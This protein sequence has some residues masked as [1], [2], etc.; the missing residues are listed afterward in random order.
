MRSA[1]HSPLAACLLG[2]APAPFLEMAVSLRR[3]VQGSS[4]RGRLV[5]TLPH[6]RYLHYKCS[7]CDLQPFRAG[8]DGV[9]RHVMHHAG[10][11]SNQVRKVYFCEICQ[12]Y[13][14]VA[15]TCVHD[16]ERLPVPFTTVASLAF[17]SELPP[18]VMALLYPRDFAILASRNFPDGTAPGFIA[19]RAAAGTASW[20]GR[21]WTVGGTGSHG[22]GGGASTPS[23]NLLPSGQASGSGLVAMHAEVE[24]A[25]ARAGMTAADIRRA[26]AAMVDLRG[27]NSVYSILRT[28]FKATPARGAGAGAPGG[29]Y[30][31]RIT[32]LNNEE[33]PAYILQREFQYHGA[34]L[35]DEL[36]GKTRVAH[37][38]L[39]QQLE[40]YFVPHAA[41][42]PFYRNFDNHGRGLHMGVREGL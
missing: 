21:A 27:V 22:G 13:S 23:S 16:E 40:D 10:A 42:R 20:A 41:S 28:F 17:R 3:V 38:F 1:Q 6:P 8:E 35:V 4:T 7:D 24:I 31:R 19:Q 14:L 11:K 37:D 33:T 36:L 29:T 12:L 9:R 39:A 30:R 5:L 25:R 34:E 18:P 26:I 15:L 32:T 2:S